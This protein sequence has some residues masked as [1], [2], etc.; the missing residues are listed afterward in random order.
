MHVYC[1][2]IQCQTNWKDVLMVIKTSEMSQTTYLLF[3]NEHQLEKHWPLLKSN[4]QNS[5]NN[6][7]YHDNDTEIYIGYNLAKGFIKSMEPLFRDKKLISLTNC[8]YPVTP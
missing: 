2:E 6:F 7:T 4:Y 5:E 3:F 8:I 1:F